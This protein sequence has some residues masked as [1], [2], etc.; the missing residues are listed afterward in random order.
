LLHRIDQ[1]FHAENYAG[2]LECAQHNARLFPESPVAW[3]HVARCAHAGGD[4]TMAEEAWR[5]VI[6]LQPHSVDALNNLGV[7]CDRQ[8]R[9]A[10]A[11]SLYDAA[12]QQAPEDASVLTNMGVLQ[13]H[14]GN[15]VL[16][17]RLQ[18][19][20]LTIR[21]GSASITTNLANLLNIAGKLS[22]AESCFRQALHLQPDFTLA[23]V[24]LG[25][26]QA[27]R[28]CLDEAEA[29][30]AQAVQQDPGYVPARTAL[31]NV[32][33]TQGKLLQGWEYFESRQTVDFFKHWFAGDPSRSA[34]HYW[35]GESLRGK[36][37]LVFPEQGL[38]DEIQFARYLR[39]LKEQGAARVTQ[40]CYP[41]QLGIMHSVYGPDQVI[42]LAEA[43]RHR[44]KYDFWTLLMSLPHCFGT[45]LE[46]IPASIPYLA[47]DPDLC[48]FWEE[49]L[50][51][52]SGR[53]KI[54][55]VWRGNPKH[56]NDSERSLPGADTLVP[57]ASC[58]DRCDFLALQRHEPHDAADFPGAF[59]MT[60]LGGRIRDFSDLAAIVSQL[61]LVISVD[62][63]VAHLA[64]A[65][66]I[67]CWVLLPFHKAD[68]RWLQG[69]EDTPW[70]PSLRLFR[71]E[72]RGDWKAPLEKMAR[73]L[74]SPLSG[75]QG[76]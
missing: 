15:L 7:L 33:L 11:R 16:A 39:R 20:A 67:P 68:W 73:C 26:L 41:E 58:A 56:T 66:G 38:G 25:I 52:R 57:L 64:G 32:L 72:K 8:H 2:A 43:T 75:S 51:S 3:T 71:Q 5:R 4:E 63:S 23:R 59:P 21:P 31:A 27:D 24:N 69:R 46:T 29:L 40:I 34:C 18:R 76:F 6:A 30:L 60:D 45:T 35:R 42:S 74:A 10:E 53:R 9:Y 13:E 54:G 36:A 19:Q 37:V 61:D 22:E 28:G 12:I 62:T 49:Q 14:L 48:A 47:A 65:L 55:V 70:Y 1:M 17:E 50:A 44:E